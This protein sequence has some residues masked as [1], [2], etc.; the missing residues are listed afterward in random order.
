MKIIKLILL[1]IVTNLFFVSCSS[2]SDNG[3][4]GD[5]NNNNFVVTM[6]ILVD[7]ES[8]ALRT[9]EGNN[10][11][12]P[13]GGEFG[14]NYQLLYGFFDNNLTSRIPIENKV[15]EILLA[16]PKENIISGEHLFGSSIAVDGFFAKMK[17]KVNNVS[18]VVNTTSGKVNIISYNT[19]TNLLHGTF[20]ITTN[21][22]TSVS[23]QVTGS[24]DYKIVE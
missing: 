13:T 7:G 20:E 9:V 8:F 10:E 12:N 24:F 23:H 3:S 5:G 14:V 15:V 1:V 21:N 16:V 18:E 22:G 6:N 4:G 11:S 19:T 17:I 2:D